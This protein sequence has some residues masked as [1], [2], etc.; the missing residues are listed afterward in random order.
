MRD[1]HTLG[2]QALSVSTI[3]QLEALHHLVARWAKVPV[4]DEVE[5]ALVR[6][7]LRLTIRPALNVQTEIDALSAAGLSAREIHDAV[8]VTA[9]FAYM[10]RL[11]DGLGAALEPRKRALAEELF[12]PD[13]VAQHQA[14]TADTGTTGHAD[15]GVSV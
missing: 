8:S 10:N 9:C 1:V 15:G 3:V 11:A 5:R 12:G 2:E 7:C 4:I 6:F 13:A 14:R